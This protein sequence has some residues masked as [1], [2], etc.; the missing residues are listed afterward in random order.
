[1]TLIEE[2]VA[3]ARIWA[4]ESNRS[5]ARLATVVVNDGKLFERITAGGTCTVTT[6]ERLLAH[7]R[8]TSNWPSAIPCEALRLLGIYD[9]E[10][11]RSPGSD[12]ESSPEVEPAA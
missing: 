2:L 7:L 10:G 9:G 12:Q 11:R 5:L 4:A 3:A 8:D 6:Y 1:M